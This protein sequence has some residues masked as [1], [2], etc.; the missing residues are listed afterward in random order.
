MRVLYVS[1]SSALTSSETD[2]LQSNNKNMQ[3]SVSIATHGLAHL[4]LT[5]KQ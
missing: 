2:S 3:E 5:E 4:L 1:R